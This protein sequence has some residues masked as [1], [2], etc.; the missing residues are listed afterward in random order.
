MVTKTGMTNKHTKGKY[1]VINYANDLAVVC[2]Q[3]KTQS[4]VAIVT[5]NVFRDE[6]CRANADLLAAAPAM[7]EALEE[8]RAVVRD[9]V[10]PQA[11]DVEFWVAD[12]ARCQEVFRKTDAALALADGEVSDA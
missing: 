8:L 1:R 9:L 12:Y 6:E 11:K 4:I 7:R 5:L 2:D 10:L 3:D